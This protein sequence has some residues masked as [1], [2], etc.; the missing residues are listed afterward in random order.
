MLT[1][2]GADDAEIIVRPCTSG[3]WQIEV[4][5]P[6]GVR[7]TTVSTEQEALTRARLLGPNVEV[8]ILPA[9]DCAQLRKS[10][11]PD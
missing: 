3:G 7:V 2:E 10:S 11:N 8:R 1:P 6:D 9:V 4:P 5:G